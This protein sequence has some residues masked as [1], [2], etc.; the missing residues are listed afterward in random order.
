MVAR[1]T[2]TGTE[3]TRKENCSVPPVTNSSNQKSRESSFHWMTS[4]LITSLSDYTIIMDDIVV[5]SALFVFL[6]RSLPL[7]CYHKLLVLFA[8]FAAVFPTTSDPRSTKT[9]WLF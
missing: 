9:T 5:M 7:V 1:M 3:D 8:F 2:G 6:S 4:L